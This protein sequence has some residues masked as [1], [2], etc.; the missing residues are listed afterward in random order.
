[1]LIQ[2][3]TRYILPAIQPR[4]KAGLQAIWDTSRA[5]QRSAYALTL[6]EALKPWFDTG[7][8]AELAARSNDI[9]ILKLTLGAAQGISAYVESNTSELE[10]FL[11][12][13]AESL[14]ARLPGNVQLVPDLRFAI[15]RD[16]YL[17]KPMQVRHWLRATALADAEQ[18]AAEMSA[19]IARQSSTERLHARW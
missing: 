16:L 10:V 8:S 3:T 19:A 6:C 4:R 15:G 2:D 12:R 1:V 14:P 5:E 18:I 7:L 13:I 9:A 17:V 11:D